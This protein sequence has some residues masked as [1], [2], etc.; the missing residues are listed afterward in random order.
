MNHEPG[1][2]FCRKYGNTAADE[3]EHLPDRYPEWYK[4]SY[5]ATQA[6]SLQ[7]LKDYD[8]TKDQID[9]FINFKCQLV[10]AN[11]YSSI[12][13]DGHRNVCIDDNL[14]T[15][16]TVFMDYQKSGHHDLEK[17]LNS[18]D[19]ISFD[20]LESTREYLIQVINRENENDNSC[21]YSGDS[22]YYA[23]I[24][25]AMEGQPNFIFPIIMQNTPSKCQKLSQMQAECRCQAPTQASKSR[26]NFY[27]K[28]SQKS[29]IFR[30][31]T[32]AKVIIAVIYSFNSTAA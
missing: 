12:W 26:T 27:A 16:T 23:N 1:D 28:S 13:C 6:Y 2:L 9:R 10:F 4:S 15:Q 19:N 7:R 20:I 5:M 31:V 30:Q 24:N 11:S 8:T 18:F 17:I 25:N 32:V 14:E 3:F 21:V 22:V 29:K